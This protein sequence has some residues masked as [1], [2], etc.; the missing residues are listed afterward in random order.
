LRYFAG[1]LV[2]A[3]SVGNAAYKRGDNHLRPLATDGQHGVVEHA[4]VAPAGKGF[5]HGFG[6]AEIH[7]CAPELFYAVILAGPQQFIGPHQAQCAV[8]LG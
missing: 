8:G 1:N 7:L 4:V 2:V 6:K 3:V 5:L